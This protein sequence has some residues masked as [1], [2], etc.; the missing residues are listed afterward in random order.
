MDDANGMT[1]GV[2][3]TTTGGAVTFDAAAVE[4]LVA[5][6]RAEAER[7]RDA[8][9]ERADAAEAARRLE[10][11]RGFAAG[12]LARLSGEGPRH[13]D[14]WATVLEAIDAVLDFDGSWASWANDNFY[15]Q[16]STAAGMLGVAFQTVRGSS[17]NRGSN[18]FRAFDPSRLRGP[19]AMKFIIG[20]FN[21]VGIR[22]LLVANLFGDDG[23]GADGDGALLDS[24]LGTWSRNLQK[25][26]LAFLQSNSRFGYD[27]NRDFRPV[28]IAFVNAFLSAVRQVLPA[29]RRDLVKTAES[30]TDDQELRFTHGRY[31]HGAIVVRGKPDVKYGNGKSELKKPFADLYTTVITYHGAD[32]RPQLRRDIP[33]PQPL[34]QQSMQVEA[35]YRSSLPTPGQNGVSPVAKG[36]LTDLV[37]G[38]LDVR[39]QDGHY[40]D[41]EWVVR[42][43]PWLL[44][45]LLVAVDFPANDL[46]VWLRDRTNEG[47]H[48]T[49]GKSEQEDTQGVE[50]ESPDLE[51]DPKRTRRDGPSEQAGAP[52]TYV[53][54]Y[55]G[56]EEPY[57]IMC[58]RILEIEA[59][60][61]GRI[62]ITPNTVRI[63]RA[64]DHKSWSTTW[65]TLAFPEWALNFLREHFHDRRIVG[66]SSSGFV[67]EE[68]L[69]LSG[70]F[71]ATVRA[72]HIPSGG[73][74][75]IK[76]EATYA[77]TYG[78]PALLAREKE[79]YDNL[80]ADPESRDHIPQVHWFGRH[81]DF[82]CLVMDLLGSSLSAEL[83]STGKALP[84]ADALEITVMLLFRL[85]FI[86]SKGFLHC[87]VKPSNICRGLDDRSREVFVIDLGLAKRMF[88]TNGDRVPFSE[89][90][91]FVGTHQFAS[92]A[93]H[94]GFE[95]C[96]WDDLES[97]AYTLLALLG[98]DPDD[99]PMSTRDS[100]E[101]CDGHLSALQTFLDECR[102]TTDLE[103]DSHF[104]ERF[105]RPVDYAHLRHL[106]DEAQLDRPSKM[107]KT[108]ATTISSSSPKKT[109]Q[110]R[111]PTSV[112]A[113]GISYS[114]EEASP[115]SE[116]SSSEPSSL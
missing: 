62:R 60:R 3:G 17:A 42:P 20:T 52:A 28:F 63:D 57:E 45:L 80:L 38:W 103:D 56:P 25:L 19:D 39:G 74:V 72:R 58:N 98:V 30:N 13:Q 68:C 15:D 7:E 75:A 65:G 24:V 86:H 104:A 112:L 106:L 82:Y 61:D 91:A 92:R 114:P 31:V 97:A 67:I 88:L 100:A 102:G 5:A 66:D 70:S 53:M 113:S 11:L 108:T 71:G 29:N 48:V 43:R 14:G 90:H 76:C 27:E 10:L 22:K 33:Q 18:D 2:D 55:D 41:A 49:I 109:P 12:G 1:D 87:D 77:R 44:R 40:V 79:V 81:D 59:M 116:P 94:F 50:D 115:S 26:R 54:S 107:Q 84:L 36:F 95:Q 93:A 32:D 110:K 101:L 105:Q 23:D 8:A 78:E 111:S 6:A 37:V 21:D 47:T 51:R 9:V 4:R 35:T 89:N 83:D 64:E 34:N 46:D 69:G 85:E 99:E 16:Y 73:A 96:P